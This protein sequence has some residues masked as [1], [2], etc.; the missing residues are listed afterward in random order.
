[1]F[2][3]LI[4]SARNDDSNGGLIV[5]S[6]QNPNLE[7]RLGPCNIGILGVDFVETINKRLIFGLTTSPN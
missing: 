5:D 7:C 2:I 6:G 4:D 3:V 1:M